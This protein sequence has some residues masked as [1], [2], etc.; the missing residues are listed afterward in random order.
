M[1]L[2]TVVF[3]A[4]LGYRL[5]TSEWRVRS[6]FLVLTAALACVFHAVLRIVLPHAAIE[7]FASET[8]WSMLLVPVAILETF[9]VWMPVL[10]IPWDR[11]RR[12]LLPQRT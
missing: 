3:I 10:V 11:F 1:K 2:V 9:G 7:A 5:G 8:S 12:E 6:S 4:W